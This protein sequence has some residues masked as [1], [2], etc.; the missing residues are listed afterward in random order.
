MGKN[1]S[2]K[3]FYKRI[4]FWGV[5]VVVLFVGITAI[6]MSG[7]SKDESK[8][9]STASTSTSK[10]SSSAEKAENKTS[11]VSDKKWTFKNDVFDAGNMTYKITKSEVVDGAGDPGTKVLVMYMDVTNNSDKEMDPSNVYMV[12]HAFQNNDTSKVQLNPGMVALDDQANSPV[13]AEE[14]AMHNSLL[15]GK[16]ATVVAVYQLENTNEVKVEF[17]NSDFQK[18]GTKTYNVQ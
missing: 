10:S 16:T 17:S 1:N 15:P 12:M 8:S 4:W 13:Q 7:G 9:S 3:P 6:G 14:D 2:N 11:D 5:V 18:I